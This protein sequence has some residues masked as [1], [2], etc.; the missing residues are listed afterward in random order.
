MSEL[1][2]LEELA[3]QLRF[4]GNNRKQNITR[5]QRMNFRQVHERAAAGNRSFEKQCERSSDRRRVLAKATE[6]PT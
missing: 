1:D 5:K 6:S 3:E 2:D 4:G